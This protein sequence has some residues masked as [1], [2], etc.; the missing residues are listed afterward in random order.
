MCKDQH[1]ARG[2]RVR[3][4]PVSKRANSMLGK[5]FS[6]I[7]KFDRDAVFWKGQ[8][9]SGS[10]TDIDVA[11]IVLIQRKV[12]SRSPVPCVLKVAL[13]V[14]YQPSEKVNSVHDLPSQVVEIERFSQRNGNR[15]IRLHVSSLILGWIKCFEKLNAPMISEFMVTSSVLGDQFWCSFLQYV[16]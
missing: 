2:H 1:T 8:W 12:P 11:T 3:A 4:R 7:K 15:S 6:W 16:R 13:D 5:I 9:T 10:R 14:F